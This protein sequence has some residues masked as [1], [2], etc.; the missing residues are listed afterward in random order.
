M[1]VRSKMIT[2]RRRP[3]TAAYRFRTPFHNTSAGLVSPIRPST[4]AAHYHHKKDSFMFS[5]KFNPANRQSPLT[6]NRYYSQGAKA[7]MPCRPNLTSSARGRP[8]E[9]MWQVPSSTKPGVIQPPKKEPWTREDNVFTNTNYVMRT[10]VDKSHA[11]DSQLKTINLYRDADKSHS[12]TAHNSLDNGSVIT[13]KSMGAA[14][15]QMGFDLEPKQV[16]DIFQCLSAR[17]TSSHHEKDQMNAATF[18][19]NLK[20]CHELDA[21]RHHPTR[22]GSSAFAYTTRRENNGVDRRHR[23]PPRQPTQQQQ[24]NSSVRIMKKSGDMH[25]TC[26]EDGDVRVE[27]SHHLRSNINPFDHKEIE[28]DHQAKLHARAEFRRKQREA[29]AA[30]KT[31]RNTRKRPMSRTQQFMLTTLDYSKYGK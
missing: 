19:E 14:L 13:K 1:C 15:E 4:A 16:T 6:R 23:F 10:M 8:I 11:H 22:F 3:A 25:N 18:M 7:P 31:H 20:D 21:E 17:N 28:H 2:P 27:Q 29:V 26:I 30:K 12:G 24:Q 9:M 5:S